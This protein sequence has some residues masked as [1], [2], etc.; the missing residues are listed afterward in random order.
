MFATIRSDGS[1]SRFVR[2]ARP[3]ARTLRDRWHTAGYLAVA[4]DY[5]TE[6]MWNDPDYLE[7]LRAR[8]VKFA[9]GD[10]ES[11]TVPLQLQTP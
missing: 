7:S 9:L 11:K 8:A 6:F 5:V 4:V 2:A 1:G 10:G 3:T